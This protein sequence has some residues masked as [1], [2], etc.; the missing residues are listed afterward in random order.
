MEKHRA[1]EMLAALTQES[2]LDAFRLLARADENG[3]PAGEIADRLGV[4]QNTMSGNLAILA[5]SGLVT[6]RR[7][8][9]SVRYSLD[10]EGVR[11]FIAFLI[12]DCCGGRPELCDLSPPPRAL[13]IDR[14]WA[15]GRV[16]N[17]LFLCTGNSARSIIAEAIMNHD[18]GARFRAFSAGSRPDGKVS[19]DAI[20]VLAKLGYPTAELR[21]KSWQEF[22]RPDAPRMDF[23]F[24][25]CDAAA[26]EPCPIWPGQPMTAHWGVPDPKAVTD[27]AAARRLA[28]ADA[29]R[30][31]E[32][33]IG[34]F[35]SLP[36]QALERSALKR[37]LD[38]IGTT[39]D[40]P[41]QPA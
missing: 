13:P 30:M 6:G 38:E 11:A 29:F 33:R 26:R 36:F 3:I 24:T 12:E 20:A 39:D 37:R 15:A 28:H 4:I 25:V 16:F 22:A 9:R 5:R 32:R 17:V 7:D 27:S 31:L 2:R 41:A 23:V 34:I 14:Q 8:G 10:P 19:P 21:S 40:H 35:T 1:I 18:D